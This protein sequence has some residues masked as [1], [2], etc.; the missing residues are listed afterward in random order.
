MLGGA[1]K[2]SES[3]LGE[4]NQCNAMKI[5]L[6]ID[7]ILLDYIIICTFIRTK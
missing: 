5:D 7:I 3:E 2:V 4:K 1:K 6:S